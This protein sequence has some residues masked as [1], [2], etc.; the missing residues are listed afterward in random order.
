MTR[1]SALAGRRVVVTRGAEKTDPLPALLEDAGATVV[2]VPLIE[3]E[4]LVPP[5]QLRA[6]VGRLRA[7]EQPG[8]RAWLV[9]TSEVAVGLLTAA[10]GAAELAGLAVAVVGP[11][12]AAA[13]GAHGLSAELIASGQEATSL[14]AE[15]AARGVAGSAVLVVAAAGGRDV[16][17]G[18]LAA[19][20][21][22]VEVVEAYRSVMPPGAA[23]ELRAAFA[24]AAVDAITFTSGSTVR[25]CS[26]AM[27]QP[28]GR[29]VAVCI[30]SVTAAAARAA[31]WSDVLT[32]VEH[33]SAGVVDALIEHLGAPQPLP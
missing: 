31:G 28:P 4:V 10:A 33:T 16:V 24:G 14:A 8:K 13:L 15:L 11:A 22:V 25:H 5:A 21:A 18:T 19:H 26:M 17:A 3:T 2:K 12:T 6:A 23:A 29:C 20:G 27:P 1:G 32:A 30:G 7:S 9:L